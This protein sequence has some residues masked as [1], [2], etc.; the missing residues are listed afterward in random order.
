MANIHSPSPLVDLQ[1]NTA[2]V[3][4]LLFIFFASFLQTP[5]LSVSERSPMSVLLM[6]FIEHFFTQTHTH[7]HS[8]TYQQRTTTSTSRYW[9]LPSSATIT[10]SPSSTS[11]TASASSRH[12]APPWPTAR[13]HCPLGKDIKKVWLDLV[14][15][16]VVHFA[17]IVSDKQ[18]GHY[19]LFHYEATEDEYDM[20]LQTDV[21]VDLVTNKVHEGHLPKMFTF[22]LSTKEPM[23]MYNYAQFY[24]SG[25]LKRAVYPGHRVTSSSSNS[26]I[27]PLRKSSIFLFFFTYSC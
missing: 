5:V 16:E 22:P 1:S 9:P 25:Y 4:M 12:R 18:G 2:L 3:V 21:I 23:T 15:E 7:T 27:K 24:G 6:H 17:V 14:L 26:F 8:A 19:M 13:W 20:P 10:S 11:P